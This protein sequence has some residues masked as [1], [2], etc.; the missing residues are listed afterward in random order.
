MGV[1]YQAE[2]LQLSRFVALKFLPDALAN[3]AQALER[4][5]REARAS[6]ALNHPNICTIYEIGEHQGRV[7]LAMEYL[8]GKTLADFIL[9][10]R[11]ELERLLDLGIEIADALDA[12]HAKGIV[13][14]DIKPANIFVTERGHAKILDFGL[15][16]TAVTATLDGATIASSN[17]PHLT[18]PGSTLGTVAYM[19]PEQALG[20]ELDARTDLFSFGAVLYEMGT[21]QMP[22]RGDT[23]AAIFDSILHKEPAPAQRLNPDVLPS[24]EHVIGKAL[25]KDRETRYQSAAEIRADLKRLKRESTSGRVTVAVPPARSAAEKHRWWLPVAGAVALVIAAIAAWALFP[26]SPPRVTGVTQ[27]THDGYALGN[28]LTDGARVYVTQIRPEG[29]SLAQVSSTGGDTSAIPAPIKSMMISDISPDHSQL[30]VGSLVPTGDQARPL[31]TLPLPAGS[32]RR[33]GE[34]EAS[35]AAWSRDG[36]QMVFIKGVNLYLAN[37]DG[38]SPH[39]LVAAPDAAFAPAFSPD[40]SRIRF[41]MQNQAN[42][43]SLWEVRSDGSNLHQL[44][45]GWHSPAREC[46]GRWTE[47]GRYYVFES[48][49]GQGNDIFAV[50]DSTGFFRRESATPTRLTTGPIVYNTAVPDVAG[51]KVFVQ[52]VQPRAE[53][54]RYDA[55]TKQFVPFL[56]GISAT[57]VAF[58]RDGK[59]VA[60]VSTSGNTLWRSRVDGSE[61]LQLTYPPVTASLP[62][63]SPDGSQIAYAA[64]QPGKLWKIYLVSAQGGTP[65]ELLP[66]NVGELDLTWSPDGTQLA[67]GRVASLNAGT[68]DIQL[69]DMKTRQ[70]STFPGSTGLFAP[71]W[72]PDGRYLAA[73]ALGSKKLMLYDFQSRTWSEWVNESANV[74]YPY[75]SSDSQYI[76]YDH[77]LT[78]NPYCLRVKVGS[79][80]PEKLFSLNGLK[81][82]FWTWGSWSGPAPDGSRLFVKDVSTQDIY[83]LD[84]EFP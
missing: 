75:W 64:S 7:F 79:H 22:F 38:S 56:G 63:W 67:F 45:K 84:V 20:K 72:S 77:L 40:G 62:F 37:A 46:C 53:L 74:D 10:P 24:L 4:F 35:G 44:L 32:P 52:G 78:E 55:A 6:S 42:S 5:R 41:S 29:L 47:D 27:I 11:I 3:D 2:D 31:W 43:Q 30:M 14:R 81:R 59:W 83:A 60:Y 17:N 9:G 57:D 21:G 82:F 80:S 68:I 13:H 66:E 18:S 54:V 16:K 70:M 73:Q 12:A 49:E 58:S 65:E 76:Y 23:S 15:A 26:V 28:M 1:V 39:L 51:K 48:S 36:R 19:S 50:A 69:V 71:R 25:D 61:R 33:L 34:I 8:E